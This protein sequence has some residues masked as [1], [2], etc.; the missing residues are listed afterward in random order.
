MGTHAGHPTLNDG[1]PPLTERQEKRLTEWVSEIKDRLGM[2]L[3]GLHALTWRVKSEYREGRGHDMEVMAMDGEHVAWLS[4]DVY[5]NGHEG[6]GSVLVT[7]NGA[8][9]DCG[10][11]N[12]GSF[13]NGG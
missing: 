13:R 7:H 5:G 4:L 8:D 3:P 9:E 2:H 11:D 10:C 1:V 12:C 6:Y